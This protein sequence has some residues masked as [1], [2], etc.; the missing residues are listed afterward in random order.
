[1]TNPSAR[2]ATDDRHVSES[3][4]VVRTPTDYLKVYSEQL[5]EVV[6]P[7]PE[8]LDCVATLRT[9]FEDAAGWALEYIPGPKSNRRGGPTWSTPANPGVRNTLG[10]LALSPASSTSDVSS[11]VS[12]IDERRAKRLAM[13]IDGLLQE[14]AETQTALAQREAQL[15]VGGTPLPMTDECCSLAERLEAVLKGGAEAVG[16]DA[17]ALY[18]LDDET[19]ELKLRSCWGLPKSR[20]RNPARPL[21]GALADL[22]AMLGHAV[23]L[24]DARIMQRWNVPEDFGAA[25]CVPVSSPTTILGTLWVFSREKR[26]FNDQQTNILEVSA[27][28][29]AADLEREMLLT[30]N[31]GGNYW[32]QQIAAAERTQRSSLP[33]ISPLLDGWQAAGW[34]AQADR[35]GGDFYDWFCLPDGLMAVAMGDSASRGLEGALLANSVRS[36]VR[37]HA[38]Y[39]RTPDRLL[40]QVNLTLWAGSAG[41]QA[42]NLFFGFIETA[43]GQTHFGSAGHLTAVVIRPGDWESLSQPSAALGTSPETQYEPQYYQLQPGESLVVFSDGFRE[44]LDRA[45][46]PL[47]E[48]A[49]AEYLASHADAHADELVAMARQRLS[50]HAATPDKMDRAIL[51]VKRTAG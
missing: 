42:A 27:G 44:A 40:G 41:D 18:L 15:A 12:A 8:E 47:G 31:A 48:S 37:S 30:K 36:A 20:L 43:N 3:K 2:R 24:E 22:E 17:A 13:A 45:G 21:Q 28:R 51:V 39:Q 4:N 16:A 6:A 7:K 46:R 5:P 23:V 29:V 35:L 9:A 14:L 11:T 26:D 25:A 19:R 38:Q 32:K 34:A 33:S 50:A 49:L 1:M 10:H